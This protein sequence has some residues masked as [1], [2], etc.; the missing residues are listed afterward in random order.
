[1][2]NALI[3]MFNAIIEGGGNSEDL[4]GVEWDGIWENTLKTKDIN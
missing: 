1:M 4:P 2:F 3:E